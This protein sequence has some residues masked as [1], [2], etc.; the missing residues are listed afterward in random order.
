MDRA[1]CQTDVRERNMSQYLHITL[2]TA[3]ILKPSSLHARFT[4][5]IEYIYDLL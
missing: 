5:S 1:A 3:Q 2:P 4:Y